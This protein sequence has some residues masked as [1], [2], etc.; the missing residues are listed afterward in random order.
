MQGKYQS[1]VSH[2]NVLRLLGTKFDK[3]GLIEGLVF[4]YAKS[5]LKPYLG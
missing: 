2:P 1:L 4:P 3:D 5:D